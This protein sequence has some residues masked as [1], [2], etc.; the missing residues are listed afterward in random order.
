MEVRI[1][2]HM[3]MAHMPKAQY[4][5][6]DL[7]ILL[8]KSRDRGVE[9][10]VMRMR[11]RH[12]KGMAGILEDIVRHQ[13]GLEEDMLVDMAVEDRVADRVV[14]DTANQCGG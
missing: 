9:Q 8:I 13:E 4:I 6:K 7:S 10:V 5:T 3:R 12:Q 14:A 1:V 2:V 11:V